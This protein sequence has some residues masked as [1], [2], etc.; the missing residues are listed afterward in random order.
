MI[1]IKA[2]KT[3]HRCA[4]VLRQKSV[5]SSNKERT[6]WGSGLSQGRISS[7]TQRRIFVEISEMGREIFN[8]HG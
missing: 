3:L 4:F 8:L 6:G 5:C 2:F 1:I 7:D